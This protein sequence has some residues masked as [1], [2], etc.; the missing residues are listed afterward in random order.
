MTNLFYFISKHFQTNT[1]LL[2]GHRPPATYESS[3]CT[4]LLSI[5]VLFLDILVGAKCYHIVALICIFLMTNIGKYL[6]ICLSAIY[7]LL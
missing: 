7:V 4:L 2:Y 5:F 6:F 3:N 1:T